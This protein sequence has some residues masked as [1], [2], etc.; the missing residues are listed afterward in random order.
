MEIEDVPLCNP[1]ELIADDPHKYDY[2]IQ[3]KD[4][5]NKEIA[6]LVYVIT[7]KPVTAIK[8]GFRNHP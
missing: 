1:I 8:N 7:Y 6:I 3:V 4:N 2:V 5:H